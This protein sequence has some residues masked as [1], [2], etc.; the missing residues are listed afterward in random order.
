MGSLMFCLMI[1]FVEVA[2]NLWYCKN[3]QRAK[4][5]PSLCN[6]GYYLGTPPWVV[7]AARRVHGSG[8]IPSIECKGPK[9]GCC[10]SL[11][12]SGISCSCRP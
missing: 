6:G 4:A 12:S 5:M 2:S 3:I 9:V 1:L 7:R 8:R 11:E 10:V